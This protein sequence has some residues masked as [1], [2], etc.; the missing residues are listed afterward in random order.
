MLAAIF[1]A[2]R[3]AYPQLQLESRSSD[4]PLAESMA[5]VDLAV[6]CCDGMPEGKWISYVVMRRQERLIAG[7]ASPPAKGLPFFQSM[8]W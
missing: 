3:E 4:D 6:H 5:G 7:K 8:S 2:L 1:A